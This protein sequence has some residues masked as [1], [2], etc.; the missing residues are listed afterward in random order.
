MATSQS[1]TIPRWRADVLTGRQI[2]GARKLLQW[3]RAL[4]SRAV[5]LSQAG[6]AALE[7]SDGPAWLTKEQEVA[8]R[9]ACELAGVEFVAEDGGGVGVRLRKTVL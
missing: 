7:S 4:L 5:G 8:V 6:I 3:S 1:V 2:R 9:S